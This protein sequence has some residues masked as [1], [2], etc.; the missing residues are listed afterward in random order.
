MPM[1]TLCETYFDIPVYLPLFIEV[2][3]CCELYTLTLT[4]GLLY[5]YSRIAGTSLL[6]LML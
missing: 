2:Y 3:Y 1:L 6:V 5:Q 4:L